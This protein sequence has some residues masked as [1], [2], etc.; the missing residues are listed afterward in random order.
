MADKKSGKLG[1]ISNYRTVQR[2]QQRVEQMKRLQQQVA[3]SDSSSA[4]ASLLCGFLS[5]L[6]AD[7]AK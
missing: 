3:G 5:N 4:A 6:Q 1:I 7:S 2:R